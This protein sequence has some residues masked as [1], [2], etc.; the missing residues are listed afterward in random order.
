MEL[1]SS[2][3]DPTTALLSEFGTRLNEVEEKQRLIKDRLLLVG[4]NLISTKEEIEKQ[5]LENN[6]K[7][8]QIEFEIKTIKQLVKKIVNEIQNFTRKSEVEILERQIKMFEP[9]EFARMKDVEQ[10]VRQELNKQKA[11]KNTE[12]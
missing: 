6:K 3:Q 8:S 10:V 5:N 4:E 11:I 7:I 12:A 2:P 1:Q 9:L